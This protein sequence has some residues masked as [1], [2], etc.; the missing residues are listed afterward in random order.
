MKNFLLTIAATFM[1][2]GAVAQHT[3]VPKAQ[4]FNPSH[5]EI[6]PRTSAV[7]SPNIIKAID[8]KSEFTN[9]CLFNA[10]DDHA[11]AYAF[12]VFDYRY[13][14]NAFVNFTTD[15][16]EDYRMQANYEQIPAESYGFFSSTFVG[17][18]IFAYCYRYYGSNTLIPLSFGYIDPKTGI[19]E[20]TVDAPYGTMTALNDMTYDPVTKRIFAV[21]M[22]YDKNDGSI[23]GSN[24]IV[25]D[26]ADPKLEM[27][28]VATVS[29]PIFVIA[30]DKGEV[31]GIIPDRQSSN[32]YLAKFSA[33]ELLDGNGKMTPINKNSGFGINIGYAQSMEFDK[34]NH[35]LWWFGQTMDDKS[36]FSEVDINKGVIKNRH[37]FYMPA[38]AVALAMPFQ[39]VKE[40]APSYV[41]NL[42]AKAADAGG[43]KITFSW[44]NPSKDFYLN[45]LTDLTKVNI[46]RDGQVVKTVDAAGVGQVQTC[47]D[48]DVPSGVHIYR[49]QPVNAEGDGVYKEVK[50]FVGHDV[51]GGV[52]GIKIKTDG[53]KATVTWSAP[54]A[55]VN[56]GW[57]D[58]TS[59]KYDVVRFPGNVKLATDITECKV[60]DEVSKFEG[61]YYEITAKNKD[62][63]GS[64]VKSDVTSF[65]PSLSIPFFSSLNTVEEF[66]KWTV[67]DNN[68]D[69]TSW[70]FDNYFDVT[71]YEFSTSAADDY[72]VSP[73]FYFEEGKEYQIRFKYWT[74]NWVNAFDF[75]P[76][77]EKMDIYYAQE[78]TAAAFQKEGKILDLVD[79]HT[80]A[81]TYLYAKQVFSAKPGKGHLAF[82]AYSDPESSIIYLQDVC[83]R[84]Y[85]ATDLSITDFKG[86]IAAV[87]GSA[88]AYSVEVMNE[89]SA[90]INKYK[91][92]LIDAETGAVLGTADGVSINPEEKKVVT[93][94][95]TPSEVGDISVSAKVELEGDTYPADNKW[96]ESIHV[97]IAPEGSANWISVNT[98]DAYYKDGL[99]HNC[100]WA[101]PF[102]FSV[103][104][105]MIQ[106]IYLDKEIAKKNIT[107]TGVLFVYDCQNEDPVT[108][109]VKISAMAS[110]KTYFEW[111][112][113]NL[114]VMA[115][116][117]DDP[118]WMPLYEGNI[119]FG[120]I[121]KDKRLV[122]KFDEPYY[123]EG[124]NLVFMY[125]SMW[126][127]DY[128]TDEKSPMFHQHNLYSE[129]EDVCQRTCKFASK[130]LDY[131]DPDKIG[132]LPATPFTMFQYL[133]G[134]QTGIMGVTADGLNF[135]IF[136]GKL[137]MSQ[138][139]DSIVVYDL[140][141][142][143]VAE[144][145]NANVLSLGILHGTYVI[146]AKAGEKTIN[147]KVSF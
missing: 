81:K 42:S 9:D 39:D 71:C 142:K 63:V 68:N 20:K 82:H 118:N 125:E 4:R 95:W 27:K 112:A 86:S 34:V 98:D 69:Y 94:E 14:T 97:E 129:G 134:D 114:L 41:R 56:G 12:M 144:V 5:Y 146:S 126:D 51:P 80:P 123:Y 47:E 141:G 19:Y 66:N 73:E 91:V 11:N 48:T 108:K 62:G 21:E 36:F 33:Q 131:P 145:R 132:S 29:T 37:D 110:E 79:F 109:P 84:E 137:K 96:K 115:Y 61:Y 43:N 117:H 105:S 44:T 133:D 26:P 16:P 138:V 28:V 65:G 75:T 87:Q 31:Y 35:R 7:T 102:N 50:A 30:A 74:A 45:P 10:N 143:A 88:S 38:Q 77:P 6:L 60:E 55:G 139:C 100:G 85:S 147:T 128:F 119:E 135:D 1:S 103:A 122:I 136:D 8:V 70:K 53:C 124:G 83:I 93:V 113:E 104:Y 2:F 89:G 15:D 58:K 120:G 92:H 116:D 22:L 130:Y 76:L 49:I 17:D 121:E 111:D 32:S 101:M 64:T 127:E 18:K 3:A 78:P 46:I 52:T 72:L 140:D 106:S 40:K 25:I 23:I 59:L 13:K 67:I 90:A 24:I 57:I 99:A 107:I 54:Y